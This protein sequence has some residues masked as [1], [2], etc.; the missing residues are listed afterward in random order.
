MNAR[1]FG[2]EAGVVAV[3]LSVT[4]AAAAPSDK[5]AGSIGGSVTSSIGIPQMGAYTATKAA[6]AQGW[7]AIASGAG[8]VYSLSLPDL[9]KVW[10]FKTG[11]DLDASPAQCGELGREPAYS[12]LVHAGPA[13]GH[14]RAADLYHYTAR[15]LYNLFTRILFKGH[16]AAP[17]LSL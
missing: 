6:Q 2:I 17:L 16:W 5:L 8:H 12:L 13:R 4:T 9:K 14:D 15:A 11:S 7:P 3:W 1:T 10:D